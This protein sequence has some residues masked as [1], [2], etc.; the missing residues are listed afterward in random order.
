M[1]REREKTSNEALEELQKKV[2]KL[3]LLEKFLKE[4]N[5]E[6]LFAFEKE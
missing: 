3:T 2:D 6:M 4:T 1:E 5:P